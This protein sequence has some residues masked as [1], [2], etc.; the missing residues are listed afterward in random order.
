MDFFMEIYYRNMYNMGIFISIEG[1]YF[2]ILFYF[3]GV[4]AQE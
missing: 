4:M 3:K 2:I 1:M